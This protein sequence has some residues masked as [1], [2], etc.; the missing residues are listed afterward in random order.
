MNLVR[1]TPVVGRL[2]VRFAVF[3][4]SPSRRSDLVG[5]LEPNFPALTLPEKRPYHARASPP[6]CSLSLIV[7]TLTGSGRT[8]PQK[9]EFGHYQ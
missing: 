1:L 2:S 7:A 3:G 5:L 4:C 9:V 8:R 6:A